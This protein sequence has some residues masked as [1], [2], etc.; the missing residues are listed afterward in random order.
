MSLLLSCPHCGRRP[1]QEFRYGGEAPARRP[2]PAAEG[3][4]LAAALYES[5]NPCGAADEW[6][7]H[8]AACR[9][10][11]VVARDTLRDTAGEGQP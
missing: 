4:Q 3:D 8:F 10:W 1:V 9:L 6:W 7:Q 11:F 2:S 5:D